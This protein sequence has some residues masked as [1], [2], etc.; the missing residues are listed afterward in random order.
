MAFYDP[1]KKIKTC[2]FSHLSIKHILVLK[3]HTDFRIVAY[4]R[5]EYIKNLYNWQRTLNQSSLDL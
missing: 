4:K 1:T 2:H 3:M 5:C